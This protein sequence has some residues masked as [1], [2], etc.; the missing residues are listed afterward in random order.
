MWF[1]ALAVITWS[2]V[3]SQS[4]APPAAAFVG[5]GIVYPIAASIT[6]LPFASAGLLGGAFAVGWTLNLLY[7]AAASAGVNTQTQPAGK[8]Q[9]DGSN[10]VP[11]KPHHPPGQIQGGTR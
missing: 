7:L 4:K 5:T 2:Y 6:A 11:L 10:V 3:K 8:G 1:V 9:T